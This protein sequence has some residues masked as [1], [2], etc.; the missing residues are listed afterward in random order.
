MLFEQTFKNISRS[1]SIVN[2][3]VKYGFEDLVVNTPLHNLLPEK[4]RLSWTRD[5]RLVVDFSSWERIRLA[6]EELGPTFIKGAQVLSNRPDLVPG[7]LI[8]EFQKLQSNVLPFATEEAK[9]I[10][11]REL[12]LPLDQ[13]FSF[14]E[15]T[16]IGSASIGQVHRARLLNGTDVVIKVQ[17]PNIRE[18]VTTDLSILKEI[19][20]RAESFL[21][22]MGLTNLYT[23]VE[24]FEKTMIKEMD[25]RV[26]AKS[27]DQFRDF[28]KEYTNFYVP[29]VY[30]EFT[31]EKVMVL[32][33]IK[34]CKITDVE[35]LK[36]WG[37]DPIVIAEAGMNIY[38][39]QIFEYGY[40]HADPHPGNILV[41]PDGVIC[42]IDFGMVGKLNR[43]DKLAFAGVLIGM[44]QQNAGMMAASLRK[45][46]VE[47]NIRDYRVFEYE[48]SEIIDEFTTQ[49]VSESNIAE[50]GTRLQKVIYDN[51]MRVPGS[52]FLL[53][54]AMAILEGIGKEIH[55]KFMVYDYVAP[56]GA[57]L[58]KDQ[59][60]PKFMAQDAWQI[61]SE[62]WAFVTGFPM[63][64]KDILRKLRRGNLRV[65]YELHGHENAVN[66]ITN[67][68]HRLGLLFFSAMLI[69]S[70]AI[71]YHAT[72]SMPLMAWIMLVFGILI[73]SLA[74]ASTLR[75][76]RKLH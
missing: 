47:D 22:S 69:I 44:S 1:R 45:L 7:A 63:D 59:L 48:L 40:F 25:Y 11:E 23:L 37:I 73:G 42:L 30:R 55:P 27:I 9:T 49:D 19:V 58:L 3:L 76:F 17:R 8:E 36:R 35:C 51:Q 71:I 24:A 67:T 34:G 39:T 61:G 15:E 60:D 21:E 2:V 56:Y 62:L 57:K 5:E 70:T 43:K 28:Y 20:V 38:L 29:K 6:V 18:V 52:V 33:L 32:E 46:A 14:F 41:R 4:R 10:I 54:R 64:V 53:L 74:I 31:T 13:I 75:N 72:P 66:Q 68:L 50:M 26:E 12:N 65:E 16:P